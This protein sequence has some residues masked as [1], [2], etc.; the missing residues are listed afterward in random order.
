MSTILHF[1]HS[2]DECFTAFKHVSYESIGIL[3]MYFEFINPFMH[4]Y[5]ENIQNIELENR[6]D[7][8]LFQNLISKYQNQY[9]SN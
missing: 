4:M 5:L 2:F 3:K 9:Y 8:E 1:D 7:L 6:I